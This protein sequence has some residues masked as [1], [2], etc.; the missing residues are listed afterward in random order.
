MIDRTQYISKECTHDEYYRE[1]AKI[2]GIHIF[3]EDFIR[4][5]ALI[6]IRDPHL[7]EIPLETWDC[8]ARAYSHYT[9]IHKAFN[10]RGDY[11]TMAGMVCVMKAAVRN[12]IISRGPFYANIEATYS[13]IEQMLKEQA[14]NPT[15]S[16]KEKLDDE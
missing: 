5:C 10:N 6:Y 1:I 3:N 8:F 4:R 2:C 14:I 9:H 16:I 11:V 13:R 12:I 15:V 7:N